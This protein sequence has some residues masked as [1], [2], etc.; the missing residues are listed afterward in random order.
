MAY[1]VSV[2]ASAAKD[3]RALDEDVRRRVGARSMRWGTIHDPAGVEKL[4]ATIIVYRVARRRLPHS[5]PDSG[6]PTHCPRDR[7]AIARRRIAKEHETC[8]ASPR[9]A[10]CRNEDPRRHQWLCVQGVEGSFPT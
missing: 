10:T 3:I 6:P 1:T 7:V 5:V 2:T 8:G 4:R 9:N